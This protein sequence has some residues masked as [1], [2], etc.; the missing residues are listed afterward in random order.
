MAVVLDGKLIFVGDD[1]RAVKW[2]NW[3]VHFAWQEA[4]YDPILRFST[5]PK[6]FDLTR[7]P[8]EMR[9]VAEPYNG[10]I[11]YPITKLLLNYQA[12]L[13]KYPNVPVGAPDTYAPKQ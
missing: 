7:D 2:R 11:Q 12:S 1:L 4:K 5:V 8:R 13:A 9:A 10:W 6:V 3:K